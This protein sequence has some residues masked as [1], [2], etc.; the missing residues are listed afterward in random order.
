MEYQM[1]RN[2][3]SSNK[4]NNESRR[5][6]KRTRSQDD[7]DDENMVYQKLPLNL[8]SILFPIPKAG[9][10][11]VWGSWSV[12]FGLSI[13]AVAAPQFPRRSRIHPFEPLAPGSSREWIVR[14]EHKFLLN[15][16]FWLF[17][18]VFFN[19]NFDIK[20]LDEIVIIILILYHEWMVW[21]QVLVVSGSGEG[22]NPKIVI[23]QLWLRNLRVR[24][25]PYP[26]RLRVWVDPSECLLAWRI[27]VH[28]SALTYG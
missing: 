3:L 6:W 17:L 26:Q 8:S 14:K 22:T 18:F 19:F 7:D 23:A 12:R 27:P 4:N 25:H 11:W 10:S 9:S 5:R 15:I 21:W 16:F 24:L 28:W 1:R 13:L 20:I 2:K